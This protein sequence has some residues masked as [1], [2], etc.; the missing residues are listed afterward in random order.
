MSCGGAHKGRQTGGDS[1]NARSALSRS[2]DALLIF[3]ATWRANAPSVPCSRNT[4]RRISST[5]AIVNSLPRWSISPG[6][7]DTAL[8]Q[9]ENVAVLPKVHCPLAKIVRDHSL[10]LVQRA[11]YGLGSMKNR[12][13][14]PCEVTGENLLGERRGG[15]GDRAVDLVSV[16]SP[17]SL[18]ERSRRRKPVWRWA[19]GNQAS[20]GMPSV[21]RRKTLVS[22]LC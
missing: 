15:L 5:A 4:S 18:T 12:H 6:V 19:D 20:G 16:R 22:S 10:P 21:T 8:R 14:E 1:C 2:M 17:P 13:G 3:P 7:A 9:S 11:Q